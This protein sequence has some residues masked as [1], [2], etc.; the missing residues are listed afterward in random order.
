MKIL[1]SG[2][3]LIFLD[4]QATCKMKDLIATRNAIIYELEFLS[5]SVN[6]N[7]ESVMIKYN[8]NLLKELLK[9]FNTN[10]EKIL[11]I[12]CNTRCEEETAN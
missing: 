11:E 8:D 1:I 4:L 3:F 2:F 12:L 10:T 9:E 7:A 5:K 6:A